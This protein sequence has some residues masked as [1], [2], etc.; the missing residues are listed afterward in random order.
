MVVGYKI[1][2]PYAHEMSRNMN[3]LVGCAFAW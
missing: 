2:K 1:I 3:W